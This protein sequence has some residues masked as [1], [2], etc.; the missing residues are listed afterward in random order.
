MS[1]VRKRGSPGCCHLPAC[2]AVSWTRECAYKTTALAGISPD[3]CWHSEHSGQRAL[4][5]AI[6]PLSR[7]HPPAGVKELQEGVLGWGAEMKDPSIC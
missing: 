2:C 3:P 6:C 1:K 4:G 7:P 5:V